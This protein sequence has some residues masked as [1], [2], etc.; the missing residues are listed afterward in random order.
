MHIGAFFRNLG[1]L[2]LKS[3]IIWIDDIGDDLDEIERFG[4]LERLKKLRVGGSGVLAVWTRC[5]L[6]PTKQLL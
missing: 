1:N 2:D 6:V 5:R 4:V 3:M